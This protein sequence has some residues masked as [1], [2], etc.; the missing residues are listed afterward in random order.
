MLVPADRR[1]GPRLR[2]LPRP[3]LDAVRSTSWSRTS[4]PSRSCRCWRRRTSS[5]RDRCAS[6]PSRIRVRGTSDGASPHST[7][8]RASR[9]GMSID[10]ERWRG[11]SGVDTDPIGGS[12]P[13]SP[14]LP[15]RPVAVSLWYRLYHGETNYEFV[16]NWKPLVRPDLRHGHPA[17]LITLGIVAVRRWPQR[18]AS[19]SSGGVGVGA[20]RGQGHVRGRGARRSSVRL[21]GRERRR[22]QARRHRTAVR[23]QGREPVRA[24]RR[25]T[26]GQAGR[27]SARRSSKKAQR[28][29]LEGGRCHLVGRLR[30]GART[31][32]NKAAKRAR[33]VLLRDRRPVHLHGDSN[34]RWH[35][36]RSPRCSTTCSSPSAS[37]HSPGSR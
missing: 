22:C 20:A 13:R 35:W 7:D 10:L 30:P 2:L 28:R 17:R 4:S 21:I 23:R 15:R 24:G 25:S 27:V 5:S 16:R 3:D 8:A 34:G 37:T 18:S 29:R 32:T 26:A 6:P 9:C 36:A 12:P 19:T 11:M 33:R 31:I 1:I 14:R